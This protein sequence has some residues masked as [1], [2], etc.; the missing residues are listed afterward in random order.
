M[1]SDSSP[2]YLLNPS[3]L[4]SLYYQTNNETGGIIDLGLS[5]RVLQAPTYDHSEH[6]HV[7]DDY[8]DLVEWNQLHPY[9]SS[10][11]SV[12]YP[13]KTTDNVVDERNMFQR[14]KH[15]GD[16]VKVNMDGVLIGRKICVLDHSSYLS[17]ASQLEDM[18]GKQALCS[19]QLFESGSDFSLWYKNRDEK[20]RI[21]GDVPWK[22]FV[23]SVTRMRIMFKDETLFRSMNT[24]V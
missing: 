24:S 6:P 14:S 18:F 8:H 11:T 15:Q 20:W 7:T 4:H 17:L 23:D 22:E 13:R 9:E 3:D 16:F 19:L 21:A 12:G 5:L 10:D 1:A 2:T